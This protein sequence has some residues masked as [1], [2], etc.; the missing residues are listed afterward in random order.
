MI[1]LKVI[2][3]RTS[4]FQRRKKKLKK[5]KAALERVH[6][7]R[8]TPVIIT[9]SKRQHDVQVPAPHEFTWNLRKDGKTV[10]PRPEASAP[11]EKVLLQQ[12]CQTLCSLRPES[13]GGGGGGGVHSGEHSELT[14]RTGHSNQHEQHPSLKP[15]G[16]IRSRL[17]DVRGREVTRCDQCREWGV[18]RGYG[19]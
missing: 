18:R 14:P 12:T 15:L 11:G 13:R 17:D 3:S 6:E 10:S 7:P 9:V 1:R 16:Y 4:L 5:R 2:W 8:S 19:T